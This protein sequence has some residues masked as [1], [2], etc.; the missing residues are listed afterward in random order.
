V[1]AEQG[2]LSQESVGEFPTTKKSI[3]SRCMRSSKANLK[4][5]SLSETKSKNGSILKKV[6]KIPDSCPD[7]VHVNISDQLKKIEFL[8]ILGEK[9]GQIFYFDILFFT[10]ITLSI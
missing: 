1:L 9:T 4:P 7:R 6:G 5:L 3:L 2:V 10:D 8:L